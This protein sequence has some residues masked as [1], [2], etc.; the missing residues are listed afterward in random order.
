MR[1]LRMKRDG[2]DTIVSNAVSHA[3]G[4]EVSLIG[5]GR[6]KDGRHCFS[7]IQKSQCYLCSVSFLKEHVDAEQDHPCEVE[8]RRHCRV[9]RLAQTLA[10]FGSA[11]AVED[12]I[13]VTL[14]SMGIPAEVSLGRS[15]AH[16]MSIIVKIGDAGRARMEE[17]KAAS[18]RTRD[19]E[20]LASTLAQA[21]NVLSPVAPSSP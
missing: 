11:R 13:E 1:E 19:Q 8:T 4:M 6:G 10:T 17:L 2:F 3:L 5:R 21:L 14:R 7:D 20:K 12:K 16:N 18:K 15:N 9:R